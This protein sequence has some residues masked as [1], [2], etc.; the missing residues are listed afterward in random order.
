MWQPLAGWQIFTP[1]M[2]GSQTRLQQSLHVPQSVPSTLPLQSDAPAGGM[3]QVPLSAPAALL[4][5]PPQQ[6]VAFTHTSPFWMQYDEAR[7]QMPPVQRPEQHSVFVVHVLPLVRQ[8]GLSGLQTRP[9]ASP[10]E[11]EPPQHWASLV[12]A[13]LSEV[14][15][16][17]LQAPLTQLSVQQSVDPAH[18]AP[19]G[20]H[21]LIPL[22]H[23]LDLPSQMFE[24]QSPFTA[25]GKP[26]PPHAGLPSPPVPSLP[27]A[28]SLPPPSSIVPSRSAPSAP[29]S[30]GVAL[31]SDPQ[32]V[33]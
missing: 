11:H 28:P 25:H 15:C 10:D 33:A 14:H 1:V 22:M 30:P 32:P 21:L 16:V 7:A 20:A 17:A 26:E 23:V 9:P 5:A 29:A 8:L 31:V 13:W 18:F 4:H 24:Q 3:P 6:S 27:L 2:Y 12:H 19:A